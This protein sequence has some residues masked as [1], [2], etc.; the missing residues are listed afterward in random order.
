MESSCLVFNLIIAQSFQKKKTN[1]DRKVKM[2]SSHINL[3]PSA[4]LSDSV[5]GPGP[6]VWEPQSQITIKCCL[7]TWEQVVM[8]FITSHRGTTSCEN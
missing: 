8:A 5:K 1:D 4:L 7:C 3:T 2:C 6:S